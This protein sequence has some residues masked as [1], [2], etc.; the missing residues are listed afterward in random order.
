MKKNF[1]TSRKK[2]DTCITVRAE[3]HMNNP[4]RMIRKFQKMVKSSGLMDELR[5]RRYY[6]S[7]SENNRERKRAKQR[8]VDK[9]NRKRE[10][11]F[12]ARDRGKSTRRKR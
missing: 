2:I 1:K 12:K 11:L 3:D 5:E 10:E 6:K 8:L 4:E 9:V 7:D